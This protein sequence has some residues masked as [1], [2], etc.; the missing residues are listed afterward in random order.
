MKLADNND[1]HKISDEFE[2]G[3]DMS[4]DGPLVVKIFSEHSTGHIFCLIKL[5]QSDVL[6]KMSVKFETGSCGVKNY[7][8]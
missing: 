7:G 8:H 3:S 2:N 1:M 6:D 5:S 4:N